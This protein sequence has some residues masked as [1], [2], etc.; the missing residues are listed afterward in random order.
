[1]VRSLC[2]VAVMERVRRDGGNRAGEARRPASPVYSARAWVERTCAAQGISVA[3]RDVTAAK[4]IAVLL[5]AGRKPVNRSDSPQSIDAAV[6]KPVPTSDGW[7]DDDAI[8]QDGSDRTL[9]G[10]SEVRPLAS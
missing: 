4:D 8:Q 10:G 1:M 5:S 7:T 3:L 9:P 6:V 2:A